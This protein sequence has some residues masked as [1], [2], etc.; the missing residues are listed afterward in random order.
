MNICV[1]E[2]NPLF[3]DALI[4]LLRRTMPEAEISHCGRIG[5]LPGYSGAT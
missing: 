5:R 2:D 4:Q 1:I 3:R